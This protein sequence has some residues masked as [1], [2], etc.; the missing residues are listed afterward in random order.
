MFIRLNL[1]TYTIVV[2]KKTLRKI[3][4]SRDAKMKE[5]NKHCNKLLEE[6]TQLLLKKLNRIIPRSSREHDQ[7]FIVLYKFKF[8]L[9]PHPFYYVKGNTLVKLVGT[10]LSSTV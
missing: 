5:V 2:L 6:Y 1:Y 4:Q 9:R 3:L 8:F 10:L 7:S